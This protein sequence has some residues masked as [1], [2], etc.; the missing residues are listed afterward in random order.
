MSLHDEM[1]GELTPEERTLFAALPREREPSRLLE[2]R[3]VRALRENGTIQAPA[4]VG[5]G[6]GRIRFPASWIAGA[7][8]AAVAL[9]ML[10]LNAGRTL[11]A[12]ETMATMT[13][14][15]EAK[16][17]QQAA[18]AVQ[19]TGSAYVS[20]LSRFATLAD[21]AGSNAA[22]TQQGREVAVQ[23]LRAAAGELVRISP[24]DPLAAGILAALDRAKTQR[25]PAP[26][27]TAGKER[28]VW[29]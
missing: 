24:D 18:V 15:V 6:A 26:G 17:T 23:M 2:E 21:S 3:T 13:A 9:F 7:A 12:R 14:V 28:T 4:R 25:T 1:D 10:G 5:G 27:D 22:Q 8:A 20:A 29:F 19:Q 11:G 16:S